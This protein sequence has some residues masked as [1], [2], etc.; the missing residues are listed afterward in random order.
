MFIKECLNVCIAPKRSNFYILFAFTAAGVV[1]CGGPKTAPRRSS[2]VQIIF[3]VGP[4]GSVKVFR[5]L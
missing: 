4:L 2:I 1:P 5:V 3:S